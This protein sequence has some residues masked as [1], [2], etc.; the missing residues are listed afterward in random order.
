LPEEFQPV[1]L[2][3]ATFGYWTGQLAGD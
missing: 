3:S 1:A 2:H